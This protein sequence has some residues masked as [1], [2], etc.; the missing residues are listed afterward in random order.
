MER[1]EFHRELI[2][3]TP[4][5]GI[6]LDAFLDQEIGFSEKTEGGTIP[7]L[8]SDFT[9]FT[10]IDPFTGKQHQTFTSASGFPL[11]FRKDF[12]ISLNP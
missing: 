2:F 4:F 9:V 10:G 5:T 1:T 8:D 7:E 6:L 3:E 11:R 12:N